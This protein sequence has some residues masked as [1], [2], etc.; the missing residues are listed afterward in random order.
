MALDPTS[1]GIAGD[2][3]APRERVAPPE[4]RCAF[5]TSRT[6]TTVPARPASLPTEA[7]FRWAVRPVGNSTLRDRVRSSV[8]GMSPAK[9]SNACCSLASKII[10]TCSFIITTSAVHGEHRATRLLAGLHVLLEQRELADV[11]QCEQFVLDLARGGRR[12]RHEHRAGR[13]RPRRQVEDAD[14]G[15]PGRVVDGRT[16][17]GEFT[18]LDA[19]SARGRR[20]APAVH[21]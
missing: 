5:C 16:R 6:R 20:P 10:R 12:E 9:P 7:Y 17:A 3:R 11:G 8:G 1:P 19:C 18:K 4:G 13:V 2:E 21:C 14:D 15:A